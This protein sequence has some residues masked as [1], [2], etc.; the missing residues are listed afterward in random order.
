MARRTQ[1][2]KYFKFVE[3][4]GSSHAPIPCSMEQVA[5]YATWLARSLKYH[6]ILNYLSGLNF[7]F[8]SH[9]LPTIDYDNFVLSATLKGIRRV[10]GDNVKQAFPLLPHQLLKMFAFLRNSAGHTAWRAAVLCSCGGSL[11][12]HM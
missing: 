8:K 11:E 1:I 3:I 7:Y 4:V 5:L 6:S 9:D 10:K 12:N 2:N